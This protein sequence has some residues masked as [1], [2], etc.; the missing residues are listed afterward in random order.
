MEEQKSIP[1]DTASL[2][3]NGHSRTTLL[4]SNATLFWRVFIPIFGTVFIS[5]LLLAILLTDEDE[6]M[7]PFPTLW[8][9]LLFAA[10][11]LG[12]L[13]LMKRTLLRLKRVEAD[14]VY[15]YVTNFW[16]TARYPWQDVMRIEETKRMGRRIAHLHLRA[17]GRFGQTI[18]FLGGSTYRE[19]LATHGKTELFHDN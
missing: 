18:S 5:G 7:L 9:R 16:L 13:F 11:F 19:W 6:L 17:S 8:V 1:T 14:D 3:Q 2:P 4:S 10:L 15:V 12:W